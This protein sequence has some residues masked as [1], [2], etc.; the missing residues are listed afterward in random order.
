MRVFWLSL[1]LVLATMSWGCRG[2]QTASAP[3]P[4][5]VSSAPRHKSVSSAPSAPSSETGQASAVAWMTDYGAAL[6]KAKEE[7]K[8]VMMDMFSQTCH[9]CK[10]LDEQVWSRS[11]VG[12]LSK[13]FVAVKVDAGLR[14]DLRAKFRVSGVP[15][16]IF[17]TADEKELGRV[18]GLTS[19]QHMMDAMNGA[20]K[21]F[22]QSGTQKK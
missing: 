12:E 11:D 21:K 7:G 18:L 5:S 19:Y 10:L 13:Q 9:F 1:S 15:T 17:M 3:R 22:E 16:T 14:P 6:K 2:G 8:P 4:K 20:L